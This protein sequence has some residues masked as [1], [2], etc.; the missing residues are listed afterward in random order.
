MYYAT[1]PDQPYGPRGGVLPSPRSPLHQG[2]QGLPP[3]AAAVYGSYPGYQPAALNGDD[4]EEQFGDDVSE[5]LGSPGRQYG[6]FQARAPK[7]AARGRA[8]QMPHARRPKEQEEPQD[9]A[10]AFMGGGSPPAES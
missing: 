4:D 10:A 5:G 8:R 1:V 6:N 3:R 7:F 9:A 2:P